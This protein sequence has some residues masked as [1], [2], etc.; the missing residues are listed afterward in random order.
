MKRIYFLCFLLILLFEFGYSQQVSPYDTSKVSKNTELNFAF[1]YKRGI[2]AK[3]GLV[4]YVENDLRTITAYV[5]G[6]VNWKIDIIK[7]CGPPGVGKPEIRYI[8]LKGNMIIVVFGKHDHA[9]VNTANG[10]VEGQC[11]D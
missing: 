10:E 2:E 1:T 4:Y 3:K 9:N 7:V 11:A 5:N 8:N 6:K